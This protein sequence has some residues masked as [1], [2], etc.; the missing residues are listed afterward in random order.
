MSLSRVFR[1]KLPV[2]LSVN[3]DQNAEAPITFV[4]T[5][6]ELGFPVAGLLY[7]PFLRYVRCAVPVLHSLDL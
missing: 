2:D 5:P 7:A 4:A 1:G 3:L 6:L